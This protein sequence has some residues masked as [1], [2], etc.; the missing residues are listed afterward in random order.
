[1]DT[2]GRKNYP[3]VVFTGKLSPVKNFFLQSLRFSTH[4][5]FYTYR[6]SLE[7]LKHL[8]AHF[9]LISASIDKKAEYRFH[10]SSINF[11]INKNNPLTNL[12]K[13]F[14]ATLKCEYHA[15]NIDL[16]M[17]PDRSIEY[18]CSESIEGNI[19]H[20]Y[21]SSK[22]ILFPDNLLSSLSPGD[23]ISL[24]NYDSKNKYKI[25]INTYNERWNS[26]RLIGIN[27]P[28][29]ILQIMLGRSILTIP[30]IDLKNIRNNI[31]SLQQRNFIKLP[32]ILW[33]DLDETLV[34][35]W[36]PIIEMLEFLKKCINH[37]HDIRLLT[38][39][40]FNVEETLKKLI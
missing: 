8:S 32:K 40:T 4:A 5:E 30:L 3:D 12:Q 37:G 20:N 11:F 1:M 21:I 24:K 27:I 35:R 34:C 22:D 6:S 28:L 26:Y 31:K 36:K 2:L 10:F 7:S 38:R 14:Y 9:H 19:E 15:A 33:F 39:H 13:N 16:I 25:D 23:V 17:N 18:I 29:L